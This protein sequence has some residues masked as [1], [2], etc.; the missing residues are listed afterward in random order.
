[1]VVMDWK[2]KQSVVN[3]PQQS[4]LLVS[5]V[6]SR[7]ALLALKPF[8][9]DLAA[10]SKPPASALNEEERLCRLSNITLERFQQSLSANATTTTTETG[11]PD[12]T[13]FTPSV[14]LVS[15]CM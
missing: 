10:W 9:D 2:F 8:T 15:T 4:Y 3:K 11:L 7:H 1:M 5:R 14:L 12:N 6:T 13:A